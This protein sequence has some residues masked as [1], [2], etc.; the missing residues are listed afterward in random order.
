MQIGQVTSFNLTDAEDETSPIYTGNRSR[1]GYFAWIKF[2]TVTSA[3]I[4]VFHGP[5]EDTMERIPDLDM[6]VSNTDGNTFD[7][8][9]NARFIKFK[10]VSA[11]PFDADVIVSRS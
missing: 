11:S 8:G 9:T 2:T 1:L 3:T 4:Q 7:I 10:I 6:A 5:T